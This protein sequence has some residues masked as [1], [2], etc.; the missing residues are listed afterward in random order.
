MTPSKDK[1]G[2]KELIGGVG[3][4]NSSVVVKDY[5]SSVF[6]LNTIKEEE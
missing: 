2:K 6:Q 4:T 3:H 5:R 1:L